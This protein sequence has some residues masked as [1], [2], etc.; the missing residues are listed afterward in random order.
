MFPPGR[1]RLATRPV[2]TGSPTATI[3]SGID[4]AAFLTA[5]EAGVPAV[6]ITSTF[7]AINSAVGKAFILSFRPSILDQNVLA[8]DVAE[9]PQAFAERRDEICLKDSS[10]IRK[11]TYPR[12]FCRLLRA[13]SERPR[14][15][16]TE[17]H[18]EL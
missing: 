10:R 14:S 6:T 5:S 16:A 11:E 8:L 3:A 9:V 15:R 13:R 12:D 2:A 7:R 1:A 4:V 18:N 17:Q